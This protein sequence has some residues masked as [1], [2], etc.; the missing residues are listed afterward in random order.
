MLIDWHS[1][2]LS[3][4][5]VELLEQRSQPPCL[6]QDA[7]GRWLCM[8]RGKLSFGLDYHETETMLAG[9]KASGID[10]AVLSLAG[11]FG[12][13]TL[14]AEEAVPLLTGYNREL[15]ML[16]QQYPKKLSGLA[17]L[18]LNDLEVAKAC[19]ETALADGLIG[20]IL[21]IDA[22]RD[23][24]S[25]IPLGPL[26]ACLNSHDAHLF[27]HPGPWPGTNY[28]APPSTD[29]DP[30]NTALRHSV[31]GVQAAISEAV[32]TLC[33]TDCLAPYPTLN[34]QVANLGG[35]LPW[36][37]ER[38]D[39][40][41]RLRTPEAR[42]PS[43]RL[44]RIWVDTAT[45]GPR[46][47]GLAAEVFGVQRLLFGSDAPIFSRQASRDALSQVEAGASVANASLRLLRHYRHD[48]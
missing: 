47:I 8:P 23:P 3:P 34:I 35:N 46:A 1:H 21:P 39:H 10:H 44:D 48:I 36:L 24:V 9:M 38:M 45:F 11:L 25:L 30:L 27:L 2:W 4:S 33:L 29:Y 43:E 22:F 6:T 37:V 16:C 12:L 15:A 19:L 42:P 17:A 20:A 40:L 31:L 13:D 28:Q 41:Q 5:V 26:L 7:R 32:L 18:P 14:P